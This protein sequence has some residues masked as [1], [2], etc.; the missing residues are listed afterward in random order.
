MA[1]S[2]FL[3]KIKS[4]I[5][6][7]YATVVSDGLFTDKCTFIDTG[8]YTLNALLSGSIYGGVPSNTITTLYG[9]SGVGKTYVLLSI[10]RHFLD[11]YPDSIV[12]HFESESALTSANFESHGID[13]DR[14]IL[15]PISTV[16]DFRD[17][18][19]TV[20]DD[21]LKEYP[22]ADDR[23][24]MM[25]CLDSLANLS[26]VKEMTDVEKGNN[27]LD[28][29]RQKVVKSAFR[30]LTLKSGQNDIPI[31]MTSHMYTT[32]EMFSKDVVTGG[33]GLVYCS[34]TILKLTKSPVRE[35]SE[36]VGNIVRVTTD[37]SRKTKEKQKVETLINFSTGLDRYYGILELAVDSKALEY[38]GRQFIVDGKKY[39]AKTVINEPEKFFT[40]EVLDKIDEYC[41]KKFT[42]GNGDI[43]VPTDDRQGE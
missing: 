17:Q 23:P 20:I 22:E 1:K 25:I 40:K 32:M 10:V 27:T 18:A 34:S 7:P 5:K 31:I 19:N 4:S 24:K 28:M 41:K 14:V 15:V 35:D 8:S 21:Y 38:N 3:K 43:E 12:V 16:E 11:N 2:S 6:N 30:T 36:V 9:E 39:Y 37:K 26:S 29:T 33:K 13:T 42:Y